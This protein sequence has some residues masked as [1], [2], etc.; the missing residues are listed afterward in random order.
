[1]TK[2]M[3]KE[4]DGLYE[5]LD[6]GKKDNKDR[7]KLLDTDIKRTDSFFEKRW[8]SSFFSQVVRY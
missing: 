2:E 4:I 7:D 6:I 3:E 1:M 5:L 8:D